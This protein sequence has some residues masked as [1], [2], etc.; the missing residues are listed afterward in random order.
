MRLLVK[1]SRA[2]LDLL[3]IWAQLATFGAAVADRAIDLIEKH[4]EVIRRFPFGGEA[5]PQFGEGVRWF[6]AGNYVIFYKPL[7]DRIQIIRVLDGR[8]D[9]PRAFWEDR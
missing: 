8:R 5:C 2:E 3:A 6:P 7:E 4:C 9:L 1:S